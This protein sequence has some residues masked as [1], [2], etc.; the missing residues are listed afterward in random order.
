MYFHVK[1][2]LSQPLH[3]ELLHNLTGYY[4]SAF[5]SVLKLNFILP[6]FTT[7]FILYCLLILYYYEKRCLDNATFS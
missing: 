5:L 3:Q 1:G 6:A 2:S 4:G 7:T